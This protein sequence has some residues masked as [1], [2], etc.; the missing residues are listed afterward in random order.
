MKKHGTLNGQKFT[1]V[2]Y[3]VREPEMG[4]GPLAFPV[5]GIISD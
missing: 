1:A 3:G 5:V 4:G 2:G